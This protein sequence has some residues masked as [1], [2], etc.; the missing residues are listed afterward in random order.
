M[1]GLLSLILGILFFPIT[2]L[3]SWV[4]V[5]PQE[6]AVILM[7]G[8]LKR[9][10]RE[11]GLY[12][13]I[14]WG[15]KVIKISTKKQAIDIPRSVV[16]DGNGNPIVVAG[17]VTYR[18]VDT[19]KAALEVE[20]ADEFVKTQALAVLKQLCSRYPYESK[21]G[22]SLK[23]EAAEIGGEMVRL[24]QEKVEAAGAEVQA[25]ELSDLTY[26]PEIASAMLVRQQAQALVDARKT[27][28]EG[29]VE[30]VS[31][32]VSML[33][34]R[35]LGIPKDEQPRMISNLLT[36]ICGDANVQP[37]LPVG[38]PPGVQ[39]DGGNARLQELLEQV[40][41]NTKPPR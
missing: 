1:A 9:L 19:K 28:V 35:D 25:F 4:I 37:T 12:W 26:A 5:H 29:A 41:K 22:E 17:V 27:I 40:V 23:S 32:A 30:I 33:E 14:L 24:L 10:L 21:E 3:F 15:R 34:E 13:N 31:D 11:P 8:K 16:A 6:E 2:L 18:F 38:A 36:V 39:D 7:W 20:K